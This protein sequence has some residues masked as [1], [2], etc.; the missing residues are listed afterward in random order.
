MLAV[1][2]AST[3]AQVVTNIAFLRTQ[4][5]AN[6]APSDTTTIYTV[7]GIVTTHTNLTSSASSLFYLQDATA[8]IAVFVN[9]GGSIRPKAGDLVRVTGPLGAF[10]GLFELNLSAANANHTV[11]TLNSSNALPSPRPFEFSQTNN[12]ALMEQ[13]IEGSYVVVSNVYLD[14]TLTNFT[15]N[16]NVRITNQAGETFT[17]RIDSRVGDIGGKPKPT[18]LV[19]IYGVMGQFDG[20]PPHD[21]GYQLFATRYADIVRVSE[22]P[23]ISP[24]AD[25]QTGVGVP[26]GPIAFTVADTQTAASTLTVTGR[27]SNT[28][29]VPDGA[30]S[31]G[32]TN[33]NR[34]ITISPAAGQQGL[35]LISVIVTDPAGNAATN[36]FQL[37]VGAPSISE[38][39]DQLTTIN[40]PAGPVS[41]TVF[42]AESDP[43]SLI[44]SAASSNTGLV[45]EASVVSLN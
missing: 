38:I 29:L 24:I 32:G 41:F 12:P 25:Q 16:S 21:S 44:L 35:T 28:N 27:S 10:N 13:L 42:D 14:R 45:S 39:P 23:S 3:Q 11:T 15:V 7:E 31:F 9:Q 4:M 19:N 1:S 36:T 34:S 20:S 8:G 30:I 33:E 18:G 37:I 17:L 43:A 6:F 5:D 26:V 40:R 2:L 22:E